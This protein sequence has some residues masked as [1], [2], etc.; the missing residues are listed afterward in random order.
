MMQQ[1]CARDRTHPQLGVH[2]V[3]HFGVRHHKRRV[4]IVLLHEV[5]DGG[6]E[7]ARTRPGTR[8]AL[9]VVQ[10]ARRDMSTTL[11]LAIQ[12]MVSL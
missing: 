2:H 8:Q 11:L 9:S 5:L 10:G 12:R 4:H 3:A 1:L 7:A 6:P